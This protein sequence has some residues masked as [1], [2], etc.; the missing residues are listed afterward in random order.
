M[1]E[2]PPCGVGAARTRLSLAPHA[3]ATTVVSAPGRAAGTPWTTTWL[4]TADAARPRVRPG[5]DAATP[6]RRERCRVI[7]LL[8]LGVGLVLPKSLQR[9]CIHSAPQKMANKH[10]IPALPPHSNPMPIC[11]RR[12][13]GQTSR[14]HAGSGL[15]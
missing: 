7:V 2:R 9:A 6:A 12:Q 15:G 13:E 1:P 3:C 4:R 14:A 8:N 10:S 11:V 5:E